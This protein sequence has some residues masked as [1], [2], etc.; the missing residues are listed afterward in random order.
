MIFGGD[1]IGARVEPKIGWRKWGGGASA[2]PLTGRRRSFLW[3]EEGSDLG[4]TVRGWLA[5]FLV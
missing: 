3:A 1:Q 4:M 2:V 5:G